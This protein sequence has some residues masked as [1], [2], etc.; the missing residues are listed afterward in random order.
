MRMLKESQRTYVR[1]IAREV[2]RDAGG[3]KDMAIELGKARLRDSPRSIIAS[4]LISVAIRLLVSLIVEWISNNVSN[5]PTSYQPHEPGYDR[6]DETDNAAY[7]VT[8]DE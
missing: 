7:E 4:I 1:S 5:P 3:N 2:F 6:W 8:D